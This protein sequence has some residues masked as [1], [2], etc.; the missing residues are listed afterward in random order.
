MTLEELFAD[1][2]TVEQYAEEFREE[3]TWYERC[4]AMHK[5]VLQGCHTDIKTLQ[6]RIQQD[7]GGSKAMISEAEEDALVAAECIRR[8]QAAQELVLQN[9]H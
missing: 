7:V 8:V 3:E 2:K 1:L 6:R 9:E 4:L 5:E